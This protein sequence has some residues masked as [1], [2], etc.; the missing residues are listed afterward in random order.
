[1]AAELTFCIEA[2]H[3]RLN[4]VQFGLDGEVDEICVDKNV[5][6]WTK[7]SVVLEEQA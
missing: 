5:V 7:L 2:V 4:D 6:W 1:M 3:H